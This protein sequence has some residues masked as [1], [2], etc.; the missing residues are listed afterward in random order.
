MTARRAAC[1]ALLALAALTAGCSNGSDDK[2]S[3]AADKPSRPATSETPTAT[4]TPGRL[5]FGS[6][7]HWSA[8]DDD[9]KSIS[10]TSTVLRYTQP[11]KDVDL[12]KEAAD[13]PNPDWSVLEVKVCVDAKSSSVTVS[14]SPW[15]L[16]FP[17]DS[18]LDAPRLSGA[19]VAKPE[20]AANG[21]TLNPGSCLRGRITYSVEHG[22][23]PDRI[24]YGAVGRDT[25]EWA[26]PKA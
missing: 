2:P 21:A 23:R 17:D 15:A 10:G 14:Q 12:P 24:V 16:G 25:V 18:R 20:Y 9:G 8:T 13:F 5:S 1:A 19:G 7:W 11:A 26:V 3:K 4:A 6:G 22:T